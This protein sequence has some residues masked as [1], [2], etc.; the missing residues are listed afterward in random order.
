MKI[1]ESEY[2]FH[3]SR[4]SGAGGQ[5]VNKVNSKV[6][7]R[8]HL[9]SS[10]IPGPVKRRFI[11]KFGNKINDIG[12][13]VVTSQEERTQKANQS[14]C[15][16]KLEDMVK[17]VAKPPKSRIK[18]KPGKGAIEDRIKQ[19]KRQGEKKRNRQLKDY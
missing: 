10:Q 14:S 15:V 8:W 19:K 9:E 7:L 17:S 13:V 6:T 1:D 12:E 11:E 5:N 4:S 2:T 16:K 3:V 18:T